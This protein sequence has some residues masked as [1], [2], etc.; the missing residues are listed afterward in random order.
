MNDKD[1]NRQL[2]QRIKKLRQGKSLS[3]AELAEKIDKSVDTISN[4]E[5]AQFLPR[6]ETALSIADALDVKLHELFRIQDMPQHD[7]QKLE[8]LDEIFDLLKDQ[9]EEMLCFTL[10]Q[11]KQLVSLKESFVDKLKR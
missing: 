1:L 3:Q 9:P 4:I 2:G 5:R 10:E 11:T 6:L 8:I 7:R